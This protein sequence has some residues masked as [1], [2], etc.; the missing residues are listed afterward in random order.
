ML[1]KARRKFSTVLMASALSTILA[2]LG[3]LGV[4]LSPVF[5]CCYA[6]KALSVR[7][8][9][10]QGEPENSIFRQNRHRCKGGSWLDRIVLEGQ[11][12]DLIFEVLGQTADRYDKKI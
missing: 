9:A 8:N 7:A 12:H 4:G 3:L 1:V 6:R 2:R 5:L 11:V 10:I